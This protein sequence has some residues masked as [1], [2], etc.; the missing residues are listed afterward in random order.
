MILLFSRLNF[1][2]YPRAIA[3]RKSRAGLYG[4]HNDALRAA[5]ISTLL[6]TFKLHQEESV[7]S[8]REILSHLPDHAINKVAV[9]RRAQKL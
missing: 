9:P 2:R 6:A 4:S 7:V 3:A 1:K 8:A 5:I